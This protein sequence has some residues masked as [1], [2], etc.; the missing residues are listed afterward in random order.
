MLR[1]KGWCDKRGSYRHTATRRRAGV[2][3][4]MNRS[5]KDKETTLIGV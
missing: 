3:L 5:V 4:V 2:G 1:D